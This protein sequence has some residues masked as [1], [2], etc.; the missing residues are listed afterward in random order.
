MRVPAINIIVARYNENIDWCHNLCRAL[1]S[2]FSS[3]IDLTLYVYNK[4]AELS[5]VHSSSLSYAYV[6][7]PLENVG[8]EGH[9][10]YHHMCEHYHDLGDYMF[11][12]QGNPFDHS[13]HV[14]ESIPFYI[15]NIV[16]GV[17]YDY[18]HISKNVIKTPLQVQR[19]KYPECKDLYETW[20]RIFGVECEIE[21]ECEFGAGAQF[22]LKRDLVLSREVDFYKRIVEMLSYSK[23]P[24]EGY[25]VERLH[26]K[27]FVGK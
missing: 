8:R 26:R 21:S 15:R 1:M 16:S 3:K 18:V 17:N 2:E 11:L 12:L 6:E 19:N 7:T 23:N 14:L 24:M 9:T 20:R 4:G 13:P 27:V 5:P 25:D 22:M 10:Y